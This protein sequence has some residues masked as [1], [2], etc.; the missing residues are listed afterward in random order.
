M[1]A[2]PF[3]RRSVRGKAGLG[4]MTLF[5]PQRAVVLIKSQPE[6]ASETA[7]AETALTLRLLMAERQATGGRSTLVPCPEGFQ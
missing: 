3:L 7:S 2:G 6:S 5:K 4:P 1:V